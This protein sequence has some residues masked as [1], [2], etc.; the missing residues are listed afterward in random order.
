MSFT[1][2]RIARS[3]E[4]HLEA[5][6]A[7]VFPLLC[8]VRE[9]EWIEPWTCEMVWSDSGVAEKDG[10]FTTRFPDDPEREIWVICRYEPERA[11]EFIRFMPGYKT[12]RLDIALTPD[13]AGTRLR[14]THT[15]TGLTDPGNSLVER[16]AGE[17]YLQRMKSLERMLAHFLRTGEMLRN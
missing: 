4:H 11:I 10:I 3:Y 8:P 15:F 17:A 2:K 9:Y 14:W 7:Q 5:S 13:D 1:P 6:P 12:T 16:E